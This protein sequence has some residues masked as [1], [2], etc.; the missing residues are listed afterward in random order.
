[1]N[2]RD[3]KTPRRSK[4]L[5]MKIQKT[6][7]ALLFSFCVLLVYVVIF[8]LFWRLGVLAVQIKDFPR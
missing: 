5:T 1:M 7:Q 2:R 6:E 4:K 8:F 3:A